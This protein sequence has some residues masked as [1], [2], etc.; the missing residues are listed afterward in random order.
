MK[1]LKL[2]FFKTNKYR[3]FMKLNV[4]IFL[5]ALL[6]F[7]I[8]YAIEWQVN[9]DKIGFFDNKH[10]FNI[11]VAG[12]DRVVLQLNDTNYTAEREGNV[13][14]NYF[15]K[16]NGQYFYKWFL[17]SGNETETTDQY[18]YDDKTTEI[19]EK[20]EKKAIK[21]E[22]MKNDKY[23]IIVEK[24]KKK[25]E[26]Y[27]V[28][29][30]KGDEDI[31]ILDNIDISGFASA[32]K[33]NVRDFVWVET[34]I[35]NYKGKIYLPSVYSKVFYCFGN[36]D[37]P[38]CEFINKCGV[39]PCYKIENQITV[40]YLDHFS[41]G[42]GGDP[43]LQFNQ[44]STKN[45]TG[46]ASNIA[47]NEID[48]L[49]NFNDGK[50]WNVT[51]KGF[52]Y[53][54]NSDNQL[55]STI[56][57]KGKTREQKTVEYFIY[58]DMTQLA[59]N[60]EKTGTFTVYIP[61]NNPQIKSAYVE[62]NNVI[63]NTQITAGQ[64]I[65]LWDGA[66]NYTLLTTSAG[67][68]AT[69]ENMV[70]VL[71]ANA[72]QAFSSIS[73]S[74]TYT[75]T[76]YTRLNAI[77]QGESAK[78]VLTYEYDSDSP[79]QIKTVRFFVG[80]LTSALAVGSSTNFTIPPLNLPENNIVIRDSFF[81]TYIYLQPT[82][83][84]DEGISINLDG[85]NAISGTPIDNV[86]TTTIDTYFLYRNV[87]DTTISHTFNFQPTAGSAINTVG[88]E[89]I[90]TYEYDANS[91]RQLNT[92]KYLIG[93][94]PN[95]YTTANTMTFS[96]KVEL[97]DNVNIKSIY[98]KVRF[99]IAYAS[100]AGTNAYT[101]II[102]VNSSLQGQSAPQVSYTLGLR[103]EQVSTSTILYNASYLY[104]LQNGNT[105]LCTVYSSATNTSY[106]TSSKGCE[107]LITYE[108]QV[109]NYIKTVDYFADETQKNTL[110]MSQLLNFSFYTPEN[111]PYL[112]Q[113]YIDVK[114]YTG[115]ATAANIL[116][117]SSINVAGRVVQSCYF[118]NTGENR[119][120][121][122]WDDVSDNITQ[123]GNYQI[124]VG[125]G[126]ATTVTRWYNSKADITYNYTGLREYNTS[127]Q[128]YS[129]GGQ[130]YN[131]I[132]NV[133]VVLTITYYNPA[134]S[135]SSF[136][137]NNRPDIE[138]AFW[139]GSAY[140]NGYFCSLN[141][142]GETPIKNEF[143]CSISSTDSN[144]I[145]AW[146][147]ANN[148][149][150]RLR[151]VW[152]DAANA[153]SDEIN[154]TS[155]YAQIN[156]TM[157]KLEVEHNST[158]NYS[159]LL[160]NINSSIVFSSTLDDIYNMSIYNFVADRWDASFCQNISAV[161]DNVYIISCN[162]TSNPQDYVSSNIVRIKLETTIDDDRATLK[163]DFVQFYIGYIFS[164]INLGE[165][166]ETPS[167]AYYSPGQTYIF[168]IT[169][170][171]EQGQS[172]I[173]TVIFEFEG[174][175]ETATVYSIIN[176]TARYYS[177]N[178][179]DLPAKTDG[180]NFKW[181]ANDSNNLWGNVFSGNYIINKQTPSL[182]ILYSSNPVN[183]PTQT[184]T[185]CNK[186]SGDY[187]SLLKLF[188]N[189]SQVAQSTGNSI[190]E[191]II[192][193]ASTWN[194]S[195]TYDESQNY[196]FYA[197]TN[198]YLYVNKGTPPIYL[199][200]NNTQAN[201]SYTYPAV[202]NVTGWLETF[203]NEGQVELFRDFISIGSGKQVS[204]VIQLASGEYNYSLIFQETQ[205]YSYYAI[206]NDR[207][208]KINKATPNIIFSITPTTPITYETSSKAICYTND[209]EVEIK[210][211]RNNTDITTENDT[212][213]VL[214]AGSW[215]YV[216]NSS[217]TQNYTFGYQSILYIVNKKNANIKVHPTSLITT[218][219]ISVTQYCT[220]DSM[221]I[222]Y[223]YRNNTLIENNTQYSPTAGYY[224]YKANI[225]DSQNYTNFEDIQ[226]LTVN[227][228]VS[229]IR[230]YLNNTEG[231]KTYT[232]EDYANITSTLN[233]S[234]KTFY[235][236]SNFTGIMQTIN[237]GQDV[238][239]NITKD[240]AAGTYNITSFWPGDENY[241][242]DIKTYFIYVNKK[243]T[244]LYLYLN[245]S[246]EN[247]NYV[248]GSAINFTVELKDL[249]NDVELWTNYT[250]G[251]WKQWDKGKSPLKNITILSFPG[252]FNFTG[253]F[254]GNQNYTQSYE[255]WLVK[256]INFKSILQDLQP[257]EINQNQ[258]SIAIGN[259]SCEGECSN[260]YIEIEAN[261]TKISDQNL[262]LNS[263]ST[264]YLGN[265]IDTS[266]TIAWN[267]TAREAGNYQISV[268]CNST[269]TGDVLSNSIFL[270]VND[271]TPP[272]WSNNVT[273]PQSPVNYGNNLYRFNVTW[274]D[275]VGIDTVLF[276]HNFSSFLKNY[277]V[278]NKD[279]NTYYFD[280]S[281][282][283]V[284]TYTYKFYAND[285]SGN[286]N[287]TD[288][289]LYKVEKAPAEIRLFLNGTEGNKSYNLRQTANITA[290]LNVSEKTIFLYSNMSGWVL[291]YS[292]TPIINYTILTEKGTFNIT[293][294]F[295]GDENY[296]SSTKTYYL[297]V[298]DVLPPIYSYIYQNASWIG[299]GN[300]LLL[301]AN[302]SDDYDLDFAWLATNETGNWQNKSYI[303]IN[304]SSSQTW[305][306]FTWSNS[307]V[308]AGR[309]VGLRIYAND[310]S[311]NENTTQIMTFI[312]NASKIWNFSTSGFI[313]SSPAVADINQDGN[314]DAVF[315]SYNKRVYALTGYNGTKIFDFLTNNSIAS[316]P[317]LATINSSVYIFVGS[318]DGNIYA[319]NGSDGSKIWNYSTQ[320]L[321]YSSPAIY[322]INGD[323]RLEIVFGSYDNNIYALD[324]ET[325]S[326]IWNYSTQGKVA[327]SP[328]IVSLVGDSL[329]V[330]GSYDKRM[331]ALNSTGNL[332]WQ[333]EAG[334]KIESSPAIADINDDSIYEVAFGSYDNK[335]YLVNA[336]NGQL[337]WSYATNNWVTAS[338]VI[339]NI[340][341]SKKVI[342]TSH[343][344]NVYCFN[345]DGSVNWTFA[346]PTGG[347]IQSSPSIADVDLDGI[348]DVIVGSSDSR[349][350]ALSG[351]SG[352]PIWHYKVNAYIFSS[353]AIADI[354]A[355]G[356]LD[357]LFGSLDK[358]Q[359]ALDPPVWQVFGGNERRTRIYDDNSPELLHIEIDNQS[360]TITSL[361]NDKS[362]NLALATI[363]ENST[364]FSTQIKLKGMQDWVNFT[365][366]IKDAYYTI[367]VFDEYNNS[368]KIEI[369]IEGERDLQPPTWL[370]NT[371]SIFT[372]K[373]NYLYKLFV[374]WT[375]DSSIELSLIEHNF[376]RTK[377]NE[378]ILG[379]FVTR[380]LPAGVYSWRSYAKD[381]SG[382]WASTDEFYLIV[383][384]AERSI[385]LTAYNATY[386][387][388][389]FVAC[390]GDRLY[391]NKTIISLEDFS[392]LSPGEWSYIC[393]KD[394]DQNYTLVSKT[395]LV[396][397]DKGLPSLS[398][399][400]NYTQYCP[401]RIKIFAS[402]N[403]IGDSDVIYMLTNQSH[404]FYGS[405][406][407]LSYIAPAGNY[408]FNYSSSFGI[409]WTDSS[410]IQKISIVDADK[411][412]NIYNKYKR[413]GDSVILISYWKDK[414]SQITK[415]VI[416]ENSLGFVRNHTIFGNE[417]IEYQ[418]SE[419][420]LKDL[421]GCMIFGGSI[422]LKIV[423]YKITVFDEFENFNSV[424]GL[425]PYIFFLR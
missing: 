151:A 137:N 321:I 331:Y 295:E 134:A 71:R 60:T 128:D 190:S 314:I 370:G 53:M 84:T 219:P 343:D 409:N 402:E 369:Y 221:L 180:Y 69:G 30:L 8:I 115:Y 170:N 135:N 39:E 169:V 1:N 196:T 140:K 3:G 366:H 17:F 422:C 24:A 390:S 248:N 245:G 410:I 380:D 372:Y 31:S 90:L 290:T 12:V 382:N 216:C 10:Q 186:S 58:Q 36:I 235:I 362:S 148:R 67:P 407:S 185:I 319:I 244:T 161:A 41:G 309:V 144:V 97:P 241:S 107:L 179:T 198:Q 207:F 212:F 43:V 68:A 322:D 401:A 287:K 285:T 396:K 152:I 388:S 189:N 23:K 175:N 424:S 45:I 29:D 78:L 262:E 332:L 132:D 418:F 420:D 112:K 351:L 227:K 66:S 47:Q 15:R 184:E 224:I 209:K 56:T 146:K 105:V 252:I 5:V 389:V 400:V 205:N 361:W 406:I 94:D 381:Y 130:N 210:I 108:Y 226:T 80:Q 239:T 283:P 11:S 27:D 141:T 18:M 270:K 263:T 346:V 386:P 229:E 143:N 103:D 98:N 354:N 222:C 323:S 423:R 237:Q 199:A 303:N 81:Q 307:S 72:T 157:Y 223:L 44:T 85:V 126:T 358:N 153:F 213:V 305:S 275:N 243:Q 302:W 306:N 158:I 2:I 280:I 4:S 102:G 425:F 99:S 267:I 301:A 73:A 259:C 155:I 395:A 109:P 165:N 174:I 127:W 345:A 101:T 91:P 333:F 260:V 35:N 312:V 294:Y 182:S 297:T 113:A 34:N 160:L 258:N 86:G 368:K 367:E 363:K 279:K 393:E 387:N 310:S 357:F 59:A 269:E 353:P 33:I 194:Y 49:L 7:P 217:Q 25:I 273:T 326:K 55:S 28:E 77:R 20:L 342:I 413:N 320:G 377:I 266:K 57:F 405:N 187:S 200:I 247:K 150:I 171:A 156:R 298:Q 26:I 230:L 292:T 142:L 330:V 324:A 145:N 268:K 42:G 249:D 195:C 136:N 62:I 329:I 13:Y 51:E 234:G 417:Y 154:I 338:P 122:C 251:N 397:V 316:S 129:F 284:G 88:T 394:E 172:Y 118:R 238:L 202:T 149:M 117:N 344:S 16:L 104:G 163:E 183:Y 272:K 240:F 181:Y 89:L 220:S 123:S 232:Y 121:T 255:S 214:P 376:T 74:G 398:L 82:S 206:T 336:S 176:S 293:A 228:G 291:K 325:G 192:L 411:P 299:V 14:Y 384:K 352:R 308:P 375:D 147:F 70:Y 236:I 421:R 257:T 264:I 225:S 250:D 124:I 95:I 341:G 383:N 374:N 246:R 75:F 313:Y 378:S 300:A 38:I 63:Y 254:S 350:Y 100:G 168:N 22:I 349:L 9:L 93:Q 271:T 211:Y 242:S 159:G 162:V 416:T 114:G 125:S 403:N 392:V 356:N 360:N 203:N 178:K 19:K 261:S 315:A 92:I 76:L 21:A 131:S 204:D 288:Q 415:A 139:N 286:Q 32:N 52:K 365:F 65:K 164:V 138:I 359:Y 412:V 348:N 177:V 256:I 231:N 197:L 337:I 111:N 282:L 334:D 339:A 276:E 335:T 215:N 385:N 208:L 96:R 274:N 37:S 233:I 355:D 218:Y 120:D 106:Y 347:R 296:T 379:E 110:S 265:L 40:I 419:Q 364:N 6:I 48:N 311:G 201:M 61:E 399:S 318:Y 371:T 304:L 191:N 373:P 46:N 166:I 277:T 327:S 281:D 173:S 408:T 328:S 188:R 317:S 133:T 167:P 340:A 54:W 119:Y 64:T 391:R 193:S 289:W 79:R 116:L 278:E 253:N 50:T 404:T 87:F 83:T 414:C